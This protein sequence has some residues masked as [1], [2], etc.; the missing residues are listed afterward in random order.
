MSII[1]SPSADRQREI[2]KVS[3]ST[4]HRHRRTGTTLTSNN[5]VIVLSGLLKILPRI[6]IEE[7]TKNVLTRLTMSSR[8]RKVPK[9]SLR[10]LHFQNIIRVAINHRMYYLTGIRYYLYLMRKATIEL[11]KDLSHLEMIKKY[12]HQIIFSTAYAL[13]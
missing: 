12:L 6:Q 4:H 9:E 8:G 13:Y 2:P 11:S 1:F 5:I 3:I 7:P 10:I